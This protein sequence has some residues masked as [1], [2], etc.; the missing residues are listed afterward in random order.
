[1]RI[2][3]GFLLGISCWLGAQS[4]EFILRVQSVY[5][6]EG[7]VFSPGEIW[8]KDRK[9]IQIGTQLKRP[10]TIK[11]IDA[12]TAIAIP[13]LVAA[14]GVYAHQGIESPYSFNWDQFALDGVDPFQT[15]WELLRAGITTV[16][17]APGAKR[18]LNGFGS[19]LKTGGK[20]RMLRPTSDL[21]FYF[22]DGALGPPKTFE[23]P[24][25][26]TP[27]SPIVHKQT[28]LPNSRMSAVYCLREFLQILSKE[29][30]Y[31]PLKDEGVQRIRNALEKK[32]PFRL[33]SEDLFYLNQLLSLQKT[34]EYP[35]LIQRPAFV[36]P[37]EEELQSFAQILTVSIQ[38]RENTSEN[39]APVNRKTF[40]LAPA[41]AQDASILLEESLRYQSLGWKP[42]D[43]ISLITQHPAK[44]LGVADR[45]GSLVAG[46]DADIVLVTPQLEVEQ[47]YVGG[48]LLFHRKE[49]NQG[50]ALKKGKNAFIVKEAR[51]HTMSQG[52]FVGDLFVQDGKILGIGPQLN[53][54][55]DVP[56]VSAK[57]KVVIPGL[58]DPLCFIGH[59]RDQESAQ[60][61]RTVAQNFANRA[62]IERFQKEEETLS[63]LRQQ[64]ITTFGGA[65][66]EMGYLSG[67]CNV[68][69]TSGGALSSLEKEFYLCSVA[70][71]NPIQTAKEILK[72]VTDARQYAKAQQQY[73]DDLKK[74]QN[75]Q[76][77]N[78]KGPEKKPT[79]PEKNKA[80][81]RFNTFENKGGIVFCEAY[82]V[83]QIRAAL[84][85]LQKDAKLKLVLFPVT[86][87]LEASSELDSTP[88]GVLLKSVEFWKNGKISL[89]FPFLQQKGIRTSYASFAYRPNQKLF[90]LLEQSRKRGIDTFSLL[91]SAT[92]DAAKLLGVDEFVGSLEI[93]KH[94]D[95]VILSGEPFH[96][97]TQIEAV[98][99]DGK[100]M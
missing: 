59:H 33:H 68:L 32:I 92:L 70:V 73:E 21:H 9:I 89:L 22:D 45:V 65:L 8:I 58:I 90:Q 47:V 50:S 24:L 99:I 77:S 66:P 55:K 80:Y 83:P 44:I 25:P 38:W 97:S 72:F 1:M 62:F 98:Y 71:G 3:F 14:A 54:D 81:E 79:T 11:E 86:E 87:A 6:G 16:Y 43:C 57:G 61:P 96:P 42:E 63:F 91:K 67:I 12:S 18:F 4:Q 93:G 37:M 27:S 60:A 95:F 26:A 2:I 7:Q 41:S 13:G 74:Y 35:F 23:P 46:K 64:G 69:K 78:P 88:F 30:Q 20:H 52:S 19:V 48:D 40:C 85:Y 10:A 31:L 49:V 36:S 53:V 28:Q 75:A 100:K 15:E 17:F 34:V 82:T 39:Y 5:T 29:P 51:L 56:V 94:A 84:K 76:K